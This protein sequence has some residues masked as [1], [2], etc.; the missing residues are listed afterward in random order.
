[1]WVKMSPAERTYLNNQSRLHPP[2]RLSHPALAD[3]TVYPEPDFG[4]VSSNASS[5]A[6]SRPFRT[7]TNTRQCGDE[8]SL[9]NG[10]RFCGLP[11]EKRLR[12]RCFRRERLRQLQDDRRNS[13][14]QSS[15]KA[16]HKANSLK[17]ASDEQPGRESGDREDQEEPQAER[18]RVTSS[19]RPDEQQDADHTNRQPDQAEAFVD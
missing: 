1:M 5:S 8:I 6:F 10:C 11:Q 18:Q 14:S 19:S 3:D 13:S 16:Q 12:L 2:R 9:L 7:V 15:G 17:I 4:G